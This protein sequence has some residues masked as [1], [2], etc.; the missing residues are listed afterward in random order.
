MAAK[1]G[2]W[3]REISDGCLFRS[4]STNPVAMYYEDLAIGRAY[5]TA[6]ID[7]TA[8][9]VASF[10]ARYDPQ[11]FHLDPVA[12][13][14]SVFGGLV[15]SGWMTAALT[16]RLMV[17]SEFNFG[18]GVVGLGV[19]TLK[20]PRPVFPGDRLTATIEVAAMRTSES[21]PGFGIVKLKTTTANQDGEIVQVMV[22]NVLVR[23]KAGNPAS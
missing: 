7:V 4:V 11:P 21:K 15:A 9:E 16:M 17:Q 13:K 2:I 6:S 10:A 19:D 8:D 23:R 1:F 18:T 20:W 5:R 14:Q 3:L 12:A 22:S